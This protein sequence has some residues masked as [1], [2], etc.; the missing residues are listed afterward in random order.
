MNLQMAHVRRGLLSAAILLAFTAGSVMVAG[1]QPERDQSRRPKITMRATPNVGTAPAR[2]VI[3]AELVG[4]AND[5]EEYYCPTVEWDWGDGTRS[6]STSDCEP[7]EESKSEIRRR[8]TV[9]HTFRRAG[10]FKLSIRLK[11]REKVVASATT[12]VSI[13][14]G[15]SG[16]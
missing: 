11:Q 4:G 9:E 5:Y 7:Y 8:F 1:Q 10:Q 2:V 3:T 14:P 12:N 16:G 13:N 15:L 6:E